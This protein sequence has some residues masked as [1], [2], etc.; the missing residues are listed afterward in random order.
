MNEWAK[1]H[2]KRRKANRFYINDQ[3]GFHCGQL[4]LNP[5]G[6]HWRSKW[7]TPQ[8]C[9][10]EGQRD[11][12]PYPLTLVSHWQMLANGALNSNTSLLPSVGWASTHGAGK[13]REKQELEMGSYW[14]VWELSITSTGEL[15]GKLTVTWRQVLAVCTPTPWW[16]LRL[17]S[18]WW[19][20]SCLNPLVVF[21]QFGTFQSY[22]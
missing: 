16:F 13:S 20:S 14:H 18:F 8:I 7:N 6:T 19:L 2:K 21:R 17:S 22:V 12:G 9:S 1:W 4:E 5:F 11:W 3:V 15:K 10:T